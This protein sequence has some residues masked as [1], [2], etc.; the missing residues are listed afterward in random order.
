MCYSLISLY[1]S[2][3]LSLLSP[4]SSLQVTS[5]EL[6]FGFEADIVLRIKTLGVTRLLNLEIDGATQ[7]S[8][9]THTHLSIS[10]ARAS[11]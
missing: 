9:T 10:T 6:L 7:P 4:F 2:F 5:N 1:L 11:V 8:S 3:F